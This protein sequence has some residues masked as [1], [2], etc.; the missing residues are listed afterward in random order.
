LI[1]TDKLISVF[2]HTFTRFEK[3][4]EIAALAIRRAITTGALPPGEFINE[5]EIAGYLNLSR[6]P[7][8]QAMVVLES[9]GLVRRVYKKGVYVTKLSGEE[10]EE[11]YHM[12]AKLEGLAVARAVPRFTPETLGKSQELLNRLIESE[13]DI[14]TFSELNMEFHLSLYEVSGWK[15]LIKKI[16]ELR[17]NTARYIA[18]SHSIKTVKAQENH[19]SE[20]VEIFNACRD[21]KADLAASLTEEHLFRNLKNL[22]KEI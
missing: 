4:D 21:G 3:A 5:I 17:N 14:E 12:R 11:L 2:N 13:Q 18:L 20:H 8:R 9:E 1:D 6:M 15:N 7:V 16:T 10:L 22:L 19:I